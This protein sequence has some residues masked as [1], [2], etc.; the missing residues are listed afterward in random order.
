M[1]PFYKIPP[2]SPFFFLLSP[3][4]LLLSSFCFLPFLLRSQPLSL[5][6]CY[7]K[8]EKNYP[9][10]QQLDLINLSEKYNLQNAS[11]AW[12]PQLQL[13][14]KASLQSDAPNFEMK[15]LMGMPLPKPISVDVPKDQ[16]QA[17][18]QLNQV[19]WDGGQI[20]SAKKT[21]RAASEVQRKQNE[22]ELYALRGRINELFF[23]IILY[24]SQIEQINVNLKELQRNLDK[25]VSYE[26][27]GFANVSDVD[28]VKVEQLTAEQHIIQL[29]TMREG[30]VAMLG[31]FMGEELAPNVVL[32]KPEMVL[33]QEI[34]NRLELQLFDASIAMQEIQN[35]QILSKNMP[36]IG[37][38][39]QGGF[40]R[41]GLNMFNKG[42]N[43]QPYAVGGVQ[44]NWSF[45]NLYTNKNEK[46]M[47][48][49]NISQIE[50]NR[51]V[52]L[53]NQSIQ[54]KQQHAITEQY[55]KILTS[56]DEIIRMRENIY[57]ASEAKTENGM[58]SVNDLMRDFNMEHA[59]KA[60][61]I[62]HEVFYLKALYD[63]RNLYNN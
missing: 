42:D 10:I 5:P 62:V 3:F 48:E 52:F 40:A 43:F 59:A 7:E 37:F 45:G 49:N 61:K 60:Q 46:R 31:A 19:I 11:R 56:D 50:V 35:T 1:K 2:T 14:G 58:M 18:L 36:K 33:V 6:V 8:T 39:L 9:L 55:R 20:R 32:Q 13:F 25:V 57:K 15:E 22:V 34:N 38:F 23:G 41:P 63:L 28:A 53:L 17:Y 27:L 30:F 47:I 4:C 29:T 51:K 44:L 26:E 16:Y 12:I 21:I 54:I 24:D